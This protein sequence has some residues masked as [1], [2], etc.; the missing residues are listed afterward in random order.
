MEQNKDLKEEIGRVRRLVAKLDRSINRRSWAAL[1]TI[2]VLVTTVVFATLVFWLVW[3]VKC[4]TQSKSEIVESIRQMETQLREYLPQLRRLEGHLA[5]GARELQ[6]LKEEVNKLSEMVAKEPQ[7]KL[8]IYTRDERTEKLRPISR[9]DHLSATIETGRPGRADVQ[10]CRDELVICDVTLKNTG[11]ANTSYP[12]IKLYIKSTPEKEDGCSES[13]HLRLCGKGVDP[14]EDAAGYD[15][16]GYTIPEH[17]FVTAIP[18]GVSMHRSLRF[19]VPRQQL[20][21]T[22]QGCTHSACLR[23]FYGGKISR[24]F[25]FFIRL[26]KECPRSSK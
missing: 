9:T 12:F 23:L 13:P 2:V 19:P 24:P 11:N 16:E 6:A 17:S 10:E 14:S 7:A 5:T 15:Y 4:N 21:T 20:A 18:V 3:A 8:E 1:V 22:S 26:G 25:P